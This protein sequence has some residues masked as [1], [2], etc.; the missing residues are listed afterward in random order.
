MIMIT[1]RNNVR[2]VVL[3]KPGTQESDESESNI[4]T[5]RQTNYKGK[6]TQ[7]QNNK[8]TTLNKKYIY[9]YILRNKKIQHT[10]YR[11]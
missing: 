1:K 7:R 11:K 5:T 4:I 6:R 3:T 10:K 8:K 9:I 2:N